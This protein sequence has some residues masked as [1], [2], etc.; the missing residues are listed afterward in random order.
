MLWIMY[1]HWLMNHK[2]N[3]YRTCSRHKSIRKCT[4]YPKEHSHMLKKYHEQMKKC[5]RFTSH[6]LNRRWAWCFCIIIFNISFQQPDKWFCFCA[7]Q[8]D[9]WSLVNWRTFCYTEWKLNHIHSTHIAITTHEFLFTLS[10]TDYQH[11][12]LVPE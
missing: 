6:I 10:K 11:L 5:W 2:R 3:G 8:F 9:L 7:Y 1:W 12:C 4:S